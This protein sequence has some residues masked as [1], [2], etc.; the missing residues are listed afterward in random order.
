MSKS[1]LLS[2]PSTTLEQ[3]IQEAQRY[4]SEFPAPPNEA[5]TCDWVIRPLLI[6]SGYSNHEILSQASDPTKKIPDYT[7]MPSTDHTWFVEAKA[8]SVA[9]ESL[10]V[11]QALNYAHSNGRQWVVLT[12]G[13]EWRLYDDHIKGV[14]ADRL[15][16][17]A[18]L[19]STGAML[20]FLGALSK[21]SMISQKVVEYA[22]ERRVREYLEGAVTDPTGAVVQAIVQVVRKHLPGVK[23]EAHAVS[24][25]LSRVQSQPVQ[26]LAASEI[27][28]E[29]GLVGEHLFYIKYKG[30][31]AT[32]R[33]GDG[34]NVILVEGSELSK[35]PVDSFAKDHA[36][37]I[38]PLIE[39]GLVE[40][41]GAAYRLKMDV[42]FKTP[43]AASD[44]VTGT[45]SNGWDFW[46]DIQNRSLHDVY[47]ALTPTK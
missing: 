1:E 31:K 2:N 37:R 32:A 26:P 33:K 28:T 43:S 13:R 7:L 30:L 12:N 42:V 45:S 22:S 24:E 9:L 46:K 27:V 14:S 8:W 19:Q 47:R 20:K 4:G 23:V 17:T 16:A 11:D 5:N 44:L 25:I 15:V 6:A 10:H 38:A 34:K 36:Q 35:A 21:E 40:D 3:A 18:S 29:P 39:A 41:T